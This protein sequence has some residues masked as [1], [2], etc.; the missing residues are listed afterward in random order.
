MQTV[1]SHARSNV[2]GYLALFVALGGTG[3]AAIAIPQGSVGARQLRNHSITPAKFNPADIAGSVRGWAIVRSNG[4]VVAAGGKPTVTVGSVTPGA[5]TLDWGVRFPARC[6]TQATI[7][8]QLSQPTETNTPPG[9]NATPTVAGYATETGTLT[10]HG[11]SET[12]VQTFNQSGQT[13]PLAFDVA[14][15]C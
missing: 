2:V 15:I 10:L 6:S 9:G 12:G 13:T 11:R 4:A 1:L 3:Y 14:V 7:D 8:A 5:F